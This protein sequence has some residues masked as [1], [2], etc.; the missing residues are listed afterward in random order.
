ML[1]FRGVPERSTTPTVLT[2][3]NFDG[4]HL[5]HRALLA[6]LKARARDL[7]LPATVLTFEPHPRELFAPDQAP[8]R[9]A[10]LR[11]KVELLA[12]CGVDR[13]HVCRFDR[14][15]AALTAGQFVERILVRGLSVRHL[16]VGDDF[17]FGKGRSG[18]FTLLQQMGQQH[19]FGVEAMQ[20]VDFGGL[21]VSSSAVRDALAA[22]N[23]EHAEELLGR[24]FVIAGRVMDGRKIGRTIGFPTA[25]IQVKRQRLPLSGVFAVT[26]SGIAAQPLPGAANIGV[27]PTVDAGMKPVLEVH[28]LDFD[29]DIYGTHVDVNFLHKLRDE[30]KFD[31]LDALKAQIAR[32]V[33]AVRAFFNTHSHTGTTH[34]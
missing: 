11:D 10:S 5:G 7:A 1:V 19:R 15:L 24:A 30:A 4:V 26:V 12:E 20:T 13:V 3:G 8:A 17:R 23:I 14:K 16:I 25:N 2:I 29:R 33:V 32:D 9:L 18:D 31:S 22:G 21:R 34:G 6:D 27:R 28:V